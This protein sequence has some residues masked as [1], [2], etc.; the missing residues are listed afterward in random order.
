MELSRRTIEHHIEAMCKTFNVTEEEVFEA[1]A[2]AEIK[3]A[4]AGLRDIRLPVHIRPVFGK[5]MRWIG[6]AQKVILKP[7]DFEGME[8][9]YAVVMPNESMEP[10]CQ[11]GNT[12]YLEPSHIVKTGELVLVA[13][14]R[15]DLRDLV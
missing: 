8:E 13:Q 1:R 11:R 2:P 6:E 3:N 12:V 14:K 7:Q 10:R 4:D 5:Q 9:T 15:L